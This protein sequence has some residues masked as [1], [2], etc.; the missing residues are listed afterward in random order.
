MKP[1]LQVAIRGK[2]GILFKGECESVTME[3]TIGVFDI[4]PDHINY[5]SVIF[6]EIVAREQTKKIWRENCQKAL[7]RVMGNAVDVLFF[8]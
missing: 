4:L 1:L 2:R 6:G 7:V 8:D 5:V 3:N